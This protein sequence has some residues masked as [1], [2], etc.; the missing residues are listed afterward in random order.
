MNLAQLKPAKEYKTEED[1]MTA[2]EKATK[3]R[4]SELLNQWLDGAIVALAQKWG[5]SWEGA[6]ARAVELRDA[7][8]IARYT[9]ENI[10]KILKANEEHPEYKSMIEF[11]YSPE[12]IEKVLTQ[13]GWNKEKICHLIEAYRK[14]E[15]DCPEILTE[16]EV[17]LINQ[18]GEDPFGLGWERQ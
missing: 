1:L 5:W 4:K 2:I 11:F 16:Y 8:T 14:D 6:K 17:D 13:R 18:H 9:T 15:T 10:I 12:G 3:H 7:E